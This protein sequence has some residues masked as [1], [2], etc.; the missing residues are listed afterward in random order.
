MIES[1][2]KCQTIRVVGKRRHA[3]PDDQIQIYTAMR[4][5]YCRKIIPDRRCNAQR[6]VV[7]TFDK[8]EIVDIHVDGVSVDDLDAFAVADGF[9]DI[10]AMGRFWA[11]NHQSGDYTG[12]SLPLVLIEWDPIGAK[13]E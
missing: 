3:R 10:S 7:I 5:K 4:T 1:G 13:D 6:E 2:D 12:R 9:E 11:D 8:G